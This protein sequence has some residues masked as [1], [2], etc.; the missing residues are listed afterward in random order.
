MLRNPANSLDTMQWTG[1]GFV[2]A[3]LLVELIHKCAR[4]TRA[5]V[6][7]LL[8]RCVGPVR[9][10]RAPLASARA[11]SRGTRAPLRKLSKKEAPKAKEM[12]PASEGKAKARTKKAD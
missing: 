8:V 12:T 4:P 9:A 11:H 3:G 2:F 1:C 5:P 10:C 6:D 7:A